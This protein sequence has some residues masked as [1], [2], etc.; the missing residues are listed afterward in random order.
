MDILHDKYSDLKAALCACGSVAVA[1]SGGVDSTFLLYTAH[2]VL[3]DRAI[4]VTAAPVFVSEREQK[5]ARD[6]CAERGITQVIIPREKLN[7]DGVRHN[8]PDRCYHCKREIFG[9]ILETAAD[10]GIP[11]VAEGVEVAG[12]YDVLREIGCEYIQGNYFSKP[13]SGQE[14]EK[15]FLQ[16]AE[17]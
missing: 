12:Q 2:E 14:F 16:E 10:R 9:K 4:A 1:F 15:Y 7:I 5:E 6:F 13:L 11:V 3:G 8:P 17:G